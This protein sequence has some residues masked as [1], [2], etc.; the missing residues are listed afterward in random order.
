MLTE[1]SGTLHEFTFSD[2]R[3]LHLLVSAHANFL[4]NS[5]SIY[6]ASECDFQQYS[7]SA[8]VKA[9]KHS[10]HSLN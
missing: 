9:E 7:T 5:T 1:N 6:M 10:M 2:E 8:C 3:A 4:A